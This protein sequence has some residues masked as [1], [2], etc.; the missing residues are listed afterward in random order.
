MREGTTPKLTYAAAT[1]QMTHNLRMRH[2][3]V[4]RTLPDV[5]ASSAAL[6]GQQ[7]DCTSNLMK[8]YAP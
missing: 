8:L 4:D 6:V 7:R 3:Y 5:K 2:D 1:N